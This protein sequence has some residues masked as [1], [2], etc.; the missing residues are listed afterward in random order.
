MGLAVHSGRPVKVYGI[1]GSSPFDKNATVTSNVF[2]IGQLLTPIALEEVPLVR[3]LGLN[4]SDHA[5]EAAHLAGR[6]TADLPKYVKL[7]IPYTYSLL[8][9]FRFPILFYKV[10]KF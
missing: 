3:A 1:S 6:A 7:Q 10:S 9:V 8:T 4:Y 5:E 2:T